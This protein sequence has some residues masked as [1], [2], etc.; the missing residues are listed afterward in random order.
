MVTVKLAVTVFGVTK[1]S[2]PHKRRC[3]SGSI[4]RPRQALLL[5]AEAEETV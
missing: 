2:G 3:C 4:S 5:H 1:Q